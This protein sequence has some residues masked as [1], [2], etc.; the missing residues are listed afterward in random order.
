M[1]RTAILFFTLILCG[2]IFAQ[3]DP[4]LSGFNNLFELSTTT[5]VQMTMPDSTKL[6]ANV[7]LPIAQKP[8][9]ITVSVPPFDTVTLELIQEGSQFIVYDSLNG[10]LA[11]NMYQMPVVFVRTPYN[12][13]TDDD[14]AAILSTF[15]FAAVIQDMRGRYASQGVYFPM[16]SDSWQKTAY[17]PLGA[18]GM[19]VT[20]LSNPM[21]SNNHEDGAN[22]LNIIL[23]DLYRTYNAETFLVCNGSVGML[24]PSALG[25]SQYQLASVNYT[26]VSKAG[27]K[28]LVPI[29]ATN[30]HYRYTA[31]NNGVFREQ[32]VEGWVSRQLASLSN[33][34]DASISNAVHSVYDYGLT[35]IQEVSDNTLDYMVANPFQGGPSGYYPN[36]H[37]RADLDASFAPIDQ[38]GKADSI[39]AFSRYSNLDIPMYHMTGWWDIFIE[40]QIETWRNI[41]AGIP[42]DSKNRS[43][44]KLVIGPWAHQTVGSASTGDVEYPE[45]V[46][47]YNI[48]LLDLNIKDSTFLNSVFNSELYQWF[49]S[50][51]NN[52]AYAKTGVPKIF[53]KESSN[54]QDIDLGFKVRFP[55]ED[56][57]VGLTDFFNYLGGKGTL[58]AIPY[59][60]SGLGK[61]Q[62]DEIEVP[63]NTQPLF[64]LDKAITEKVTD[65]SE[66]S[67]VRYYVVGPI[68]DGDQ[69][70]D[71][72]GNY[73]REDSVFPP[74]S[75]IEYFDLFLNNQMGLS[76]AAPQNSAGSTSY[77]HDPDNPVFT[78]GGANMITRT[79]SGDRKSQGQMDF[80]DPELSKYTSDRQDVVTFLSNEIKDSLCIIG[81][82]K[83]QLHVSAQP[84]DYPDIPFNSDYF[85]R[86][87]DVYPD[88]RELFV[89]EGCV[90]A[91]FR[92]YVESIYNG[93]ENVNAAYQN[94]ETDQKYLLQFLSMPIAYT[95]GDHHRIKMLVSSSN[96][97]RY[98]SNPG[99]PIDGKS[100]KRWKPGSGKV[101]EYDNISVPARKINQTLF[102]S[103]FHPSSISIPVLGSIQFYEEDFQKDSCERVMLNYVV[104]PNPAND[105][106]YVRTGSTV[107]KSLSIHNSMGQV[108]LKD[109][110][111][112]SKF[113]SLSDVSSGVYMVKASSNGCETKP[114][115]LIIAK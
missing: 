34:E 18:H 12:K 113:F 10:K 96:H 57:S 39:G 102:H 1:K 81:N 62:E 78:V 24:G 28:C 115:K 65:F 63:V 21:N 95:F 71:K 93:G 76:V 56:Y 112:Q 40:G 4:V 83:V 20:A 101:F 61:T 60:W 49:R 48:D 35:S 67:N 5:E 103:S 92:E 42:K 26:D 86:I 109:E 90:N 72:L 29:V 79:P 87:I 2:G 58:P 33:D 82:S 3:D 7:T 44:Q 15:G 94:M 73:W 100:F 47:K 19:D 22:S 17:H 111:R 80:S 6:A 88:G 70:N 84:V 51:L 13:N 77:L 74:S 36:S 32:L 14:L 75:G 107:E 105:Y 106:I 59:E 99:F 68:D 104:Y 50:Y 69:D 52:N 43:L 9:K 37:I 31:V 25:N 91:G 41:M 64:T 23:N 11:D 53:I 114:F 45:N 16:Y 54:W 66:L 55:S 27:L 108:I 38:S 89:F 46:I 30:E 8:L 97:P 98:Q 110:F 85:V